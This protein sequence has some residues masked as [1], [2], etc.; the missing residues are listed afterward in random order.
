M[1]YKY[2][3]KIELFAGNFELVKEHSID[4][5]VRLASKIARDITCRADEDTDQIYFGIFR[6]KDRINNL[7]TENDAELYD[8]RSNLQNN[9]ETGKQVYPIGV[10]VKVIN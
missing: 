3:G 7:F 8:L 2:L 10:Y 4:S 9:M 1:Q 6:D 5:L